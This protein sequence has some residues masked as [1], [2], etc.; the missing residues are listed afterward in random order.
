[1]KACDIQPQRVVCLFTQRS[2]SKI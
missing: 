1:M 2:L